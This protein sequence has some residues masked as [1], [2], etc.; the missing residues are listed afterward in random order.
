MEGLGGVVGRGLG[1]GYEGRVE[2]A[3]AWE[4]EVNG[5][6]RAAACGM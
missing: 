5:E 6:H 2:Q 4:E 1:T 3:D